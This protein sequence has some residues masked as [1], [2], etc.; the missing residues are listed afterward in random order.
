MV[1]GF[2]LLRRSRRP[3]WTS[4]FGMYVP[5]H[6]ARLLHQ[7]LFALCLISGNNSPLPS[8]PAQQGSGYQDAWRT[9]RRRLLPAGSPTKLRSV[10]TPSRQYTAAADRLPFLV[11]KVAAL[12]CAFD[13]RRNLSAPS[14]GRQAPFHAEF[15]SAEQ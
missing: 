7:T 14:E 10:N 3:P 6:R 1:L 13:G 11:R 5:P 9:L 4:Q 8:R 15:K 12:E 2:T